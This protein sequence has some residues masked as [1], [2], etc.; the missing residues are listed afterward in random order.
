MLKLAASVSGLARLAEHGDD[1]LLVTY[2][3]QARARPAE[4]PLPNTQPVTGTM[5]PG[6][7]STV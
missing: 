3:L 4:R 5:T 7:G 6:R 2:G 1:A